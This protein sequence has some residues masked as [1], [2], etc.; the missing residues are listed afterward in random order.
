[1]RERRNALGGYLPQRRRRVEPMPVPPLATFER[2]LKSTEEREISTTMAFVQMLQILLRDKAL[3][4]RVVPIVPTSRA[5]SAWRHVPPA[6]HLEPARPALHAEDADQLMF[7]KESKD[8]QIL[9]EGINE[10]GGMC[11]WIAAGDV[12]LDARRA[13]DP[14]LHLLLDVRVPAHRR[15]RVGG[16]RHALARASCSA[17]PRDARR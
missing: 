13:D 16:R 2:L 3:G 6:R 14:F 15:P 8:G 1:M 9:Q 7:Y 10:A 17:A 11:D 5:R 4:K 12:V